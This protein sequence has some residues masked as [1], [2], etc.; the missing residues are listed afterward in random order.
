MASFMLNPSIVDI[1]YYDFKRSKNF[2]KNGSVENRL[3]SV[4]FLFKNI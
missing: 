4:Y 1:L 3:R 2:S